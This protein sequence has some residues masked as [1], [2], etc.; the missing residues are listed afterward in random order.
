MRIFNRLY[1]KVYATVVGTLIMA[2]VV[3]AAIWSSG[4]EQAMARN[5]FGMASGVASAALGDPAAPKLADQLKSLARLS[6][7]ARVGPRRL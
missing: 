2:F 6:Q 4:P 5:A 7:A 3:S 1:L